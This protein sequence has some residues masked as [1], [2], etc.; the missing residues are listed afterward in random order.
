MSKIVK[1]SQLNYFAQQFYNKVKTYANGL[2]DVL[3][4]KVEANTDAIEELQEGLGVI[5]DIHLDATANN[6]YN[7][8]T[9]KVELY[10]NDTTEVYESIFIPFT[11]TNGSSYD[12][13]YKLGANSTFVNG[14]KYFDENG[15]NINSDLIESEG[16]YDQR[17][18]EGLYVGLDSYYMTSVDD[19]TVS[20]VSNMFNRMGLNI[21]ELY[22]QDINGDYIAIET[23][24][25]YMA[26]MTA[27]ST[28]FGT[29]AI[30][31]VVGTKVEVDM[32]ELT[33][34]IE[35]NANNITSLTDRVKAVES[36]ITNEYIDNIINGLQ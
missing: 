4:A 29:I 16:S 36:V 14:Y 30:A 32:S 19:F 22:Y 1:K 35:T 28:R 17:V 9:G 18:A 23:M 25:N 5:E 13:L 15:N 8:E 10:L 31:T 2:N 26:I 7:G 11:P 34:D 20:L 6:K 33:D 3:N 27:D 21:S 24:D 12:Y